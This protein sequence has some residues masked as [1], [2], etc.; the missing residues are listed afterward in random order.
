M[1]LKINGFREEHIIDTRFE[2]LNGEWTEVPNVNTI[3]YIYAYDITTKRKL[4]IRLEIIHSMCGSWW[5]TST[6]AEVSIEEIKFF[7][8]TWHL[9]PEYDGIIDNFN[10]YEDFEC[11]YF[12]YSICGGD[13]YYPSGDYTVHR[14]FFNKG[15]RHMDNRPVWIISGEVDTTESRTTEYTSEII[16]YLDER[17]IIN[18]SKIPDE[19]TTSFIVLNN[20]HGLRAITRRKTIMDRCIGEPLFINLIF[21]IVRDRGK[22]VWI[23]HGASALGKSYLAEMIQSRSDLTV[24]E[25]DISSK[26]PDSI[27]T[28]IVVLG[29]KYKDFT[30]EQVTS[31]CNTDSTIIHV[32][33]EKGTEYPD[34]GDIDKKHVLLE[35]IK[36]EVAFR[37]GNLGYE[38][39]K[40]SF[41]SSVDLL[42]T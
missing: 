34:Q 7:K 21:R 40:N 35:Q 1:K 33:F 38:D 14:S 23:F 2:H 17:L 28:D 42:S 36:E 4:E 8:S 31:R 19:I 25:T 30:L 11:Q 27:S 39:A 5:T 26:L 20:M 41:E 9:K 12:E 6:N 24:Y 22:P 15:L 18:T 3:T 16:H 37:P 32:Y 29:N 13:E 10:P